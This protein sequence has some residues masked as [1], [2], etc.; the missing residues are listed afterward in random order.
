MSL[1]IINLVFIL[2]QKFHKNNKFRF[3]YVSSEY[4]FGLDCSTQS[5]TSIIIDSNS[6]IYRKNINFDKEIYLILE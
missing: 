4:F 3:F 1:N 5:L 6:I 2:H